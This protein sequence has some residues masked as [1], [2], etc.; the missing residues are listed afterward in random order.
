MQQVLTST[1]SLRVDNTRSFPG[2]AKT[3][4]LPTQREAVQLFENYVKNIDYLQHVLHTPSVRRLL[5]EVYIKLAEPQ[6]VEPCHVALVLSIF[7]S[8]AY[9]W[10]SRN[11]H[12]LLFVTLDDAN[13]ASLLWSKAALDLLEHSRRTTCGSIEDIQATVILSFL[14]LNLEGLSATSRSLMR[15]ALIIARDISLYKVD[16]HHH[17]RRSNHQD[18]GIEIEVKRRVWWHVVATDWSISLFR[19]CFRIPANI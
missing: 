16:A 7:A 9:Y 12:D 4:W 3:I 13:Q 17:E 15:T 1:S 14:V 10:T 18:D 8:T 11:D 2:F 6:P 19:I 5:D